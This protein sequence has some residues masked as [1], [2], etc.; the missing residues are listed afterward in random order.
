MK[1][2]FTTILFCIKSETTTPTNDPFGGFGFSRASK[3][4]YPSSFVDDAAEKDCWDDASAGVDVVL[5]KYLLPL[6]RR[7]APCCDASDNDDVAE[8]EMAEVDMAEDNDDDDVPTAEA[9]RLPICLLN[10]SILS[11]WTY[12]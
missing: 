6:M 2:T 9:T 4:I 3:G 10:A 5:L 12:M 11:L 1:L 8:H 7:Q